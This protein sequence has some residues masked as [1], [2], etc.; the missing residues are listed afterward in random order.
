MRKPWPV[1]RTDEEAERFV[2]GA[3]LTEHDFSA[4]VPV[5]FELRR[6]DRAVSLRPP[7]ALL[8][9]VK[10]TAARQGIPCPRFVRQA[11]EPAVIIE[12]AQ[13]RGGR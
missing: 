8:D 10:R 4:M 5:R 1:L 11:I 13:P 6:K 3:N 9:A 12:S 7:E 2:A